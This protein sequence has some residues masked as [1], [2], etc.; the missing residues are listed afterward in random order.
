MDSSEYLHNLS[1]KSNLFDFYKTFMYLSK[2]FNIL[3]IRERER[4]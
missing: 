3:V 1:S 4:E 2:K